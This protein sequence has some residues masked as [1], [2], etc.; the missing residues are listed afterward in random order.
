MDGKNEASHRSYV[1]Y[2]RFLF[3]F[4]VGKNRKH[5]SGVT[6]STPPTETMNVIIHA[7]FENLLQIDRG[8]NVLTDF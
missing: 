4:R 8:R 3:S 2:G 1:E 5:S 7:D 6:F